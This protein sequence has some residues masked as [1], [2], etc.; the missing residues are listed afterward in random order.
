[1]MEEA[2]KGRSN[3]YRGGIHSAWVPLVAELGPPQGGEN[4]FLGK[5]VFEKIQNVFYQKECV[6]RPSWTLPAR[7]KKTKNGKIRFFKTLW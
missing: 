1:M 3:T 2:N 5:L 4:Y 6:P 7:P